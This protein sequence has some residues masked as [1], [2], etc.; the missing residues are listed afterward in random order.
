MKSLPTL[1]HLIC[2]GLCLLVMAPDAEAAPARWSSPVVSPTEMEGLF[3]GS[4]DLDGHTILRSASLPWFT[5]QGQ[6]HHFSDDLR[7]GG[8]EVSEGDGLYHA[9]QHY[10]I[11]VEGGVVKAAVSYT[12]SDVARTDASSAQWSSW[13][14]FQGPRGD[15]HF[16]WRMDLDV[17]GQ[18]SN[19]A[20]VARGGAEGFT[21]VSHEGAISLNPDVAFEVV[22][23]RSYL[24]GTR[25]VFQPMAEDHAQVWVTR[26]EPGDTSDLS[27]ADGERTDEPGDYVIWYETR[28]ADV[29]GGITGPDVEAMTASRVNAIMEEDKMTSSVWLDASAYVFGV[30]RSIQTAFATANINVTSVYRSDASLPDDTSSTN[31]ELHSLM[32]GN[33]DYESQDSS[34]NWYSWLGMVLNS[35]SGPGVLGI[36]FDD[37][38]TNNDSKPRQGAAVFA[39]AHGTDADWPSGDTAQAEMILSAA[40]EQGH[41]YNQ[42]H[43]DYCPTQ[44]F[45]EKATLKNNSAI[46]GYAFNDTGKWIFGWNSIDSMTNDPEEYIRPGHG[47]PFTQGG[48][49]TGYGDHISNHSSTSCR[50]F[51]CW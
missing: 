27:S 38:A 15:Y 8:L 23:T 7:V 31:A 41:V 18:T 40:H 37:G 13:V 24:Q 43:E 50:R 36:M 9:V 11:P 1:G 46:M 6:S 45:F 34:T 49:Y 3:L 2:G 12:L 20:Q 33:K 39:A 30:N 25:V 48:Q 19:L 47:Q 5:Y 26:F 17:G 4:A 51:C 22:D 10:A 14:D 42:H 35:A 21:T 29:V 32:V 16:Y 44:S 28:L